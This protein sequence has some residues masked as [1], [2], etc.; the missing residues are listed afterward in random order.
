[1]ARLIRQGQVIP[2]AFKVYWVSI[3]YESFEGSSFND[4]IEITNVID[5]TISMTTEHYVSKE[6]F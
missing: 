4:R 5:D 3:Q 1:M 2:S 6:I